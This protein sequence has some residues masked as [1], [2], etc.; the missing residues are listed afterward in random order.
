MLSVPE[1]APGPYEVV[2]SAA[3][4]PETSASTVFTVP[5]TP[6]PTTSPRIT[7][8]TTPTPTVLQQ[9]WCCADGDVFPA[10]EAL[11]AD[12]GGNF[13]NTRQEADD[14]CQPPPPPVGWIVGGFMGVMAA[15]GAILRTRIKVRRRASQEQARE[16]EPP[17]QCEPGTRCC[18]KV[19]IKAEMASGKVKYL[20]LRAYNAVSGE[21]SEEKRAGRDIIDR[22]NAVVDLRRRG[23]SD[24]ELQQHIS[25]I[26][27]ALAQLMTAWVTG[28][29]SIRD[30]SVFVHIEGGKVT[31]QFTRYH[32]KRRGELSTSEKEDEWK[33]TVKDN[34]DEHI[35]GFVGP[36]PSE[37]EA[38]ERFT[39]DFAQMLAVFVRKV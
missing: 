25:P 32:C 31:C 8:T 36:V 9:G 26:A 30:V 7:P 11:C 19:K 33:A 10:S 1:L 20:Y 37:L 16:H 34:Y 4:P 23:G 13:F 3:G 2:A 38:L 39:S 27:E 29:P 24:E 17:D 18:H 6:A 22:L 15:S 21:K 35:G 5:G 28:A 14:F 12:E